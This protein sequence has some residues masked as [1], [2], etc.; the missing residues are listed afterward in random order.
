MEK[1][2]TAENAETAEFF[3]KAN[4]AMHPGGLQSLCLLQDLRGILFGR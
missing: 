4:D 2:S 3:P 1:I